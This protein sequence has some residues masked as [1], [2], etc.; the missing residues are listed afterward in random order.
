[1][2]TGGAPIA[3]GAILLDFWVKLKDFTFSKSRKVSGLRST[4]ADDNFYSQRGYILPRDIFTK[5]LPEI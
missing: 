1:M 4:L 3:E 5:G 2:F